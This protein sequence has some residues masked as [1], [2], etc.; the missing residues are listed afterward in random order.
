MKF[1]QLIGCIILIYLGLA[2]VSSGYINLNGIVKLGFDGMNGAQEATQ[3][4]VQT[5]RNKRRLLPKPLPE[6]DQ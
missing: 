3:T 2:A 6:D 1:A 5:Q 4:H